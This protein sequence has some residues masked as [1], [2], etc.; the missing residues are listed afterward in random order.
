[1][2]VYL[3]VRH[4]IPFDYRGPVGSLAAVT[5]ATDILRMVL[6]HVE[7]IVPRFARFFPPT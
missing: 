5:S 7:G 4:E 2:D 3:K 1:M 6:T